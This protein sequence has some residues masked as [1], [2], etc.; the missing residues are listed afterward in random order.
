MVWVIKKKYPPFYDLGS[1]FQEKG[2]LN[3]KEN[4]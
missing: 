3:K 4:D 2:L 1:Q